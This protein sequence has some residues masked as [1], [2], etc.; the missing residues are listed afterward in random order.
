MHQ[1][2]PPSA[3]IRWISSRLD[4]LGSRRHLPHWLSSKGPNYQRRG[5]LISVGTI[6]GHFEG[7]TPLEV[8]QGGL[9]L[10]QY[11][12]GSPGTCNPEETGLPGVPVS[13]SPTLFS[14]SGSVWLP[15]VSWTE[16]TI[17]KSPF[18]VRCGV[19][20]CRGCVDGRT[21]CW[22]FFEWLVKVR[23]TG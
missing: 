12:T 3:K 7:K 19:H 8:Q 10:E 16:T 18:F 15:P 23:A 22:F 2:I 13:W 9:V 21:N 11:C 6:V 1:S 20:F 14:G 5:L 17:E 4:F